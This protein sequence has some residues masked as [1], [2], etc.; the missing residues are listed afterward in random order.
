VQ[1]WFAVHEQP[2]MPEHQPVFFADNLVER[3]VGHVADAAPLNLVTLTE[4][5]VQV[6]VVGYFNVLNEGIMVELDFSA[7]ISC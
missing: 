1:G 2:S 4:R 3:F 7:V 6:A 5:T